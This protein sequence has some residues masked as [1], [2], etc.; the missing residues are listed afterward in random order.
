MVH[1]D[2][3]HLGKSPVRHD[4]TLMGTFLEALSN[5]LHKCLVPHVFDLNWVLKNVIDTVPKKARKIKTQIL[6]VR[7]RDFKCFHK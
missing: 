5:I 1:E 7:K 2:F 6:T 4:I 3:N